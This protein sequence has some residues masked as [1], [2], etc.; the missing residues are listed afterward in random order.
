MIT[1]DGDSVLVRKRL[2]ELRRCRGMGKITSMNEGGIKEDVSVS[3]HTV[4]T[5]LENEGG[6]ACPGCQLQVEYNLEACTWIRPGVPS[7][8]RVYVS[9]A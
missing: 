8:F 3:L 6:L 4:R 2:M 5:G 7:S 9:S 1:G